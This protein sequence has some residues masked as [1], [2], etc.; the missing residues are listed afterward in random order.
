MTSSAVLTRRRWLGALG[1]AG[2]GLAAAACGPLARGTG[3]LEKP[4]AGR[5]VTLQFTHWDDIRQRPDT[6]LVWYNWIFD[7]FAQKNPGARAEFIH[8]T[9]NYVEKFLVSH[10]SGTPI[11]DLAALSITAGR[12]LYDRGALTEVDAFIKKVPELAPSKYID[13]ANFY[14]RAAGKHFSLPAWANSSCLLLNGR[15]LR[16]AGLDPKGADLRTWDDLVRYSQTLTKRDGAG[17]I[18]ELGFPFELPGIE[19]WATWAYA[20]RADIQDA[21]VTKATFNNPAV[22]EMMLFRRTAY[23]RFQVN[24]SDDLKNLHADQRGDLFRPQKQAIRHFNFGARSNIVGGVYLPRDFEFWLVGTPPGPS[25]RGPGAATWVNQMGIPKGAK[26]PELSFA[27]GRTALDLEGQSR[28]H[29][30]ALLEPSL[31]DYYQSREYTQLARDNP[32]LKVGEDLF[33]RG[34]TYPFFRR[35]SDVTTDIVPILHDGISGKLDVQQS[36]QEAV[37]RANLV[38]AG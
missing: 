19:E 37:R 15:M 25:G 4:V 29:H 38:L 13:A 26:D 11:A 17:R 12:D 34:K 23:N 31:K 6:Y 9:G 14:R 27:L 28:M 16:I 5:A 35:F 32:L 10:A 24:W 3:G 8:T 33:A 22:V 30:M 18:S 36:L 2:V 7:K 21:E 20:N 1:G